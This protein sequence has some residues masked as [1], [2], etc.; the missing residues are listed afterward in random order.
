MN[1]NQGAC[2]N[3]ADAIQRVNAWVKKSQ[4]LG[5]DFYANTLPHLNPGDVFDAYEATGRT[6][7][8]SDT[9]EEAL[10]GPFATVFLHQHPDEEPANWRQFVTGHYDKQYV[11]GFY[12]GFR[13]AVPNAFQSPDTFNL[14]YIRGVYDGVMA[15][16]AVF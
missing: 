10:C 6:P 8:A 13:L 2:L 4:E 3:I 1:T 9:L 5:H 14:Q 11:E 12:R 16:A 15:H 7:V